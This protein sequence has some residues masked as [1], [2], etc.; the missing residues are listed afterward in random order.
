M[1]METLWCMKKNDIRE[2]IYHRDIPIALTPCLKAGCDMWRGGECIQI[3]KAG[4][5]DKP[6]VW[7]R[8]DNFG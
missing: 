1:I 4:K 3:R 7:S 8:Q 2:L 5:P 6:R